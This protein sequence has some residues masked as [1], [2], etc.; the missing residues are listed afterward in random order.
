[1]GAPASS[2]VGPATAP[3]DGDGHSFLGDAPA[4]PGSSDVNAMPPQ[5]SPELVH[6]AYAP[7]SEPDPTLEPPAPSAQP[8]PQDLGLPMPP[9][10]PDFAQQGATDPNPA[11][12]PPAPS[13]NQPERL[14]DI[15]EQPQPTTP[16]VEPPAP[17]VP[18]AQP[19]TPPATPPSNDPGQFKIP[20]Q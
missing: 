15:L 8:G 7:P 3:S 16:A 19:E 12:A 20:G 11:Y 13:S 14:G 17:T 5:S 18:P 1:M 6:S 9:P 2:G 10:V 4:A